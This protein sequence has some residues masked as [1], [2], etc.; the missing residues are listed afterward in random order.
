MRTPTCTL[1]VQ[2]C[3]QRMCLCVHGLRRERSADW[4]PAHRVPGVWPAIPSP[5]PAKEECDPHIQIRKLRHWPGGPAR[6]PSKSL[7]SFDPV[8]ASVG[9]ECPVPH[10]TTCVGP[11]EPKKPKTFLNEAAWVISGKEP[12]ARRSRKLGPS[13]G[14]PAFQRPDV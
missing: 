1:A 7:A 14:A 8:S 13:S 9:G 10:V 6:D 4:T 12:A 5:E 2:D 3:S 11:G